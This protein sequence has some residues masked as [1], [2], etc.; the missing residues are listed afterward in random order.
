MK[1]KAFTLTEMMI[2]TVLFGLIVAMAIPAFQKVRHSSLKRMVERGE[3]LTPEQTEAYRN[4]R[5]RFEKKTSTNKVELEK[6]YQ[7]IIIDGR[8][9]YLVP[10]E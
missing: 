4:L 9:F 3:R 2:C 10:K 8:T 6:N 1:T 5:K 7:E